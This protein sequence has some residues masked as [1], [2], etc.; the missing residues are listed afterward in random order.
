MSDRPSEQLRRAQE[1]LRV[2]LR[3]GQGPTDLDDFAV[4]ADLPAGAVRAAA[5]GTT[6]PERTELPADGAPPAGLTS[7]PGARYTVVASDLLGSDLAVPQAATVHVA[8]LLVFRGT[9]PVQFRSGFSVVPDPGPVVEL[10]R[11]VDVEAVR[12]DDETAAQLGIES[13]AVVLL[14]VVLGVTAGGDRRLDFAYSRAD[15][16]RIVTD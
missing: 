3:R 1:L 8:E 7:T 15:L 14:Q 11:P 2:L 10:L 9:V 5:R 13:G 4:R 16:V 6:G 12:V